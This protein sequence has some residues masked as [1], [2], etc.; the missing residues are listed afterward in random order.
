IAASLLLA[1]A[2][3]T[4]LERDTW[5]VNLPE[6]VELHSPSSEEW[7]IVLKKRIA[8]GML[9]VRAKT[10]VNKDDDGETEVSVD[11]HLAFEIARNSARERYEVPIDSWSYSKCYQGGLNAPMQVTPFGVPTAGFLISTHD[12]DCGMHGTTD[13]ENLIFVDVRP[14]KPR[15]VKLSV[16]TVEL[17]GY[18]NGGTYGRDGKLV[19][20]WMRSEFVCKQSQNIYSTV[21]D[22]VEVR[23]FTLFGG[24]ALGVEGAH[25][26]LEAA[27]SASDQPVIVD[28]MGPLVPVTRVGD[29]RLYAILESVDAQMPVF[30]LYRDGRIV[31]VTPEDLSDEFREPRERAKEEPDAIPMTEVKN[32]ANFR[33]R[34]LAHMEHSHLL[35][36]VLESGE[37]KARSLFWI[38]VDPENLKLAALRVASTA[39]EDEDR[40]RF[41][42][43]SIVSYQSVDESHFAVTAYGPW[44]DDVFNGA[45]CAG[46]QDDDCAVFK[47]VIGWSP[48]GFSKKFDEQPLDPSAPQVTIAPD[49]TLGTAPRENGQP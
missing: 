18:A 36:V 17:W 41:V 46:E 19:C 33:A 22:F 15:A 47:G 25:S 42:P 11:A 20:D 39:R 30:Y 9:T 3:I 38:A 13:T 4:R 16:D 32:V 29:A 27:A 24:K 28:G 44:T 8:G 45:S 10:D 2:V 31:S 6:A 35:Q 5:S 21:A 48:D 14:P 49:G 40:A 7:P 26:L 23:R 37:D 1:T 43:G 12:S 34:E